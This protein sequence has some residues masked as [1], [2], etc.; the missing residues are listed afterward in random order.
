MASRKSTPDIMGDLMGG[1]AVKEENPKTINKESGKAVNPPMS[2]HSSPL[3]PTFS[4]PQPVAKEKNISPK[5]I[6]ETLKLEEI[7]E[8]VTLSL[9]TEL[10]SQL[11]DKWIELRKL[12][13][14]KQ[15]SKSLIIQKAIEIALYEFSESREKSSIFTMISNS[16][17][18]KE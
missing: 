17:S 3:A 13:G 4:L 14:S 16:L 5:E 9:P 18:A 2:K 6:E 12:L 7:K 15:V 8:K 11:E 1:I 10:L